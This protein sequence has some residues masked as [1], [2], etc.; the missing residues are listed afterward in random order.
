[1]VKLKADE[2][3]IQVSPIT[4]TIYAGRI[5][6]TGKYP[7]WQQKKDVTEQTL[8]AVARY[9]DG[10]FTEIEFPSGSLVWKPK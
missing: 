6:N 4:N 7:I 1:M 5:S 8:S 9:M 2:I 10:H 3:Q